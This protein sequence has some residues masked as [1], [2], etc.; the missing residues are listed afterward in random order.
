MQIFR[1][2]D[3]FSA[4]FLCKNGAYV[5]V[6]TPETGDTPL[7]LAAKFDSLKILTEKLIDLGADIDAQNDRSL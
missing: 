2:G 4:L 7:H 6:S 3:E 5:N 1:L